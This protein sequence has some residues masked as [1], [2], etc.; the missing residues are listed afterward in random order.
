MD[1]NVFI[2]INV[3]NVESVR[4]FKEEKEISLNKE[5]KVFF[6]DHIFISALDFI[7]L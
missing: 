6:S 5:K 4:D 3:S 7:Y 1:L 2:C